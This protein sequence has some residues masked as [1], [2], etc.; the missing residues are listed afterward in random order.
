MIAYVI[1]KDFAIKN[2][3]TSTSKK[4][5]IVADRF[6]SE[7][8]CTCEITIEYN[9][10]FSDLCN[11]GEFLY[12]PS[13]DVYSNFFQI[14]SAE[15]D[16]TNHTATLY[17]DN[18]LLW[19][20][21]QRARSGPYGRVSEIGQR[22]EWYLTE[23]TTTGYSRFP[24]AVKI[25]EI[26]NIRKAGDTTATTAK[27]AIEKICE[28]FNCEIVFSYLLEDKTVKPYIEIYEKNS[29]R[30][31][32][33]ILTVGK[34]LSELSK[35]ENCTSVVTSVYIRGGIKAS[36]RYEM[37]SNMY[38]D[39][40]LEIGAVC[41]ANN[42]PYINRQL[43]SASNISQMTN[44]EI[45]YE[46]N[47]NYYRGTTTGTNQPTVTGWETEEGFAVNISATS[48]IGDED[49]IYTALPSYDDGDFFTDNNGRIA[50]R[51]AW[52]VYAAN[53]S[54]ALTGFGAEIALKADDLETTEP[55]EVLAAA[56]ALLNENKNPVI[57]F[58]CECTKRVTKG[59]YYTLAVPEEGVYISARCL[60]FEESETDGTYKPTFGNYLQKENA[61]EVMARNAR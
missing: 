38:G 2:T 29:G 47:G 36:K 4:Y 48:T 59:A 37:P 15:V 20:Y 55:S 16:Y 26:A 11:V 54:A 39:A 5:K 30:E 53:V 17:G 57:T 6:I 22:V 50:S 18:N 13:R 61:F 8:N 10:R 31:T 23:I 33:E 27:E 58:D 14:L 25:N 51:S 49:Y 1:G 32:G 43:S 42:I 12:I 3:A 24:V 19:F 56:I 35:N 60:G 52:A 46:Y 34:E 40:D 44:P 41:I 21:S 9:G 28:L 7:N 45:V